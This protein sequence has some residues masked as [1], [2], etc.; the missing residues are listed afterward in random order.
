[1]SNIFIKNNNE[2]HSA[3]ESPEKTPEMGIS[4]LMLFN[5]FN[6]TITKR[7][8]A[9]NSVIIKMRAIIIFIEW[10]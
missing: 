9:N 6:T 7:A 8:I 2:N 4:S 10:Y 1:M 5:F 3:I